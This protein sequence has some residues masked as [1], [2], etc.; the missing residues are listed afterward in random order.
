MEMNTVLK[1]Q[2]KTP[3]EKEVYEHLFLSESD[4]SQMGYETQMACLFAL[5]YIRIHCQMSFIEELLKRW[6]QMILGEGWKVA[7]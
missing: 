7:M 4:A 2:N 1:K 6:S 5:E 3:K